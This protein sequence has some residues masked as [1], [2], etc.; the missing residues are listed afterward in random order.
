[1]RERGTGFRLAARQWGTR[2]VEMRRRGVLGALLNETAICEERRV[3]VELDV[4]D[5]G[6]G[7]CRRI[8]VEAAGRE[9]ERIELPSISEWMGF[10]LTQHTP[11]ADLG[12]LEEGRARG[13]G[14]GWRCGWF[15]QE[16]RR[17][18]RRRA[19]AQRTWR[20]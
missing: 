14:Q 3:R 20:R 4:E 16:G 13:G 15:A 8:V 11:S 7:A 9:G 17:T 1:M 5:V 6:R 18:A 12:L 10:R 19:T 2:L